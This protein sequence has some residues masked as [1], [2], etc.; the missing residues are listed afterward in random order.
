MILHAHS[1]LYRGLSLPDV[2]T[3]KNRDKNNDTYVDDADTWA[4]SLRYGSAATSQ[5]MELIAHGAQQW[6]NVQ[7]VSG[8][9]T[10]FDKCA[11]QCLAWQEKLGSLHI[12]M[13]LPTKISLTDVRGASSTIRRL[14]ANEPNV[15]LGY[16]LAP[17]GNQIEEYKSHRSKVVHVCEAAA[18]MMLTENTAAIML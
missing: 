4:A 3:G 14:R 13:D 9:A 11:V 1:L 7:D 8:G 16:S 18:N 15:G 10:A 2:V 12:N 6:T 17:D 5:V